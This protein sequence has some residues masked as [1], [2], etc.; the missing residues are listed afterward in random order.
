MPRHPY[1]Q[2]A[3]LS[4]FYVITPIS[5]PRRFARRYELYFVFK[6]MCEAAGVNLITI[7]QAFG[8]REFMVTHPRDPMN[9]QVRTV[10]ELWHK[11]NL[12]NIA[13]A[14]AAKLGAREIAW[15]DAD[16]RPLCDDRTWFEETWHAL[17]HYEFVQMGESLV[18]LDLRGNIKGAPQN[19]FMANYVKLGS[20]DA[21]RLKQISIEQA[22]DYNNSSG[23]KQ[24]SELFIGHPGGAWACS[25][26]AFNKVGGLIDYSI[27]GSGDHYMAYALLGT[28]EA[29]RLGVAV[30]SVY[31]KK[32][33]AWQTSAE[34]WIKRDVGFVP[35]T[36]SHDFHGPKSKRGYS[37]RWRI[38]TDNGFDPDSDLKRDAQGLLQLE[39]IEPRQIKMRDQ[40]RAYFASRMEDSTEG[41]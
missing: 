19:L 6:K 31:E 40:I 20:P 34:H 1:K 37:T 30:T 41:G 27:L 12:I 24:G 23:L 21:A 22:S 4:K 26:D 15:V 5:N 29:S 10:E 36:I 11:E 14:H 8:D 9:L 16:V 38:L 28:L 39:T 33:L 13:A 3:D 18:D 35:G 32:L 25:M 2:T 7:E 17:Q